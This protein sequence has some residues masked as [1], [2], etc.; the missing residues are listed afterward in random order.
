MPAST[1]TPKGDGA[2]RF[3]AEAELRWP[4]TVAI[5][6]SL[7]L[8]AALPTLLPSWVR[9]GVIG[10]C[11]ALLIPVFVFNPGRLAKEASWARRLS[12][13]AAFILLGANLVAFVDLL[14]GLINT[15]SPDP[16]RLLLGALQVW[17]TQVIS[18][19]V[20]YWELDRG[21]PVIRRLRAR[22][23][24]PDADFRFPQDED[25][26]LP[27]DTPARE[28]R[29]AFF[30]YLYF[31]ATNSMAFSPTDVMPLTHRVKGLMLA[32]SIAGFLLLALAIAR[33]VNVLG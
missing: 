4:V 6:V 10:V 9:F 19:A 20:I 12:L 17:T 5:L 32:Q 30:D 8:Y 3:R 13:T 33:A 18:F 22:E 24:H 14:V 16:Q 31:S 7:A 1:P 27:G 21:G 2:E 28:W 29:P 11:I 25:V 26:A 15:D 23:E